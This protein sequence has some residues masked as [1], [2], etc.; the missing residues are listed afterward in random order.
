MTPR[1][2]VKRS[3]PRLTVDLSG[4]PDMGPGITRHAVGDWLSR[5]KGRRPALLDGDQDARARALIEQPRAT[6][7]AYMTD[8]P[9]SHLFALL[10]SAAAV[11]D[12]VDRIVVIADARV[13]Q[14]LRMLIDCCCDP[15]FNELTRGER[16]S[17]PRFSALVDPSDMEQVNGLLRLVTRRPW[18]H[19][20]DDH[21][22]VVVLRDTS[23]P[24][25]AGMDALIERVTESLQQHAGLDRWKKRWLLVAEEGDRWCTWAKQH[26]CQEVF[27]PQGAWCDPQTVP[28]FYSSGLM[29]ASGLLGIDVV[30]LLEGAVQVSDEY[31]QGPVAESV[32]WQYAAT[33]AVVSGSGPGT[34]WLSAEGQALQSCAQWLESVWCHYAG[35]LPPRSAR[36]RY[37][38]KLDEGA[39]ADRLGMA[40]ARPGSGCVTRL[41]ALQARTGGSLVDPGAAVAASPGFPSAEIRLPCVNESS[42]GQLVQAM[43]LAAATCGEL[44]RAES[45]A[46]GT[47]FA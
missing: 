40:E 4:L 43:L 47:A 41:K 11:R 27:R 19:D 26:Q 42:I 28:V 32:A 30:K 21:W 2:Y 10:R 18:G 5:F 1:A 25:A 39:A 3:I 35:P 31:A 22:G 15:F 6:L 16:G 33:A 38:S 29:L 8:R 7:S 34:P 36:V 12:L 13:V 45:S 23:E 20:V 44:V 17:R 37:L 9:Q 46:D 14:A 24:Q